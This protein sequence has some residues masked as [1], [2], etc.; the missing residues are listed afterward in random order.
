[1]PSYTKYESVCKPSR[2]ILES[3]GVVN[4]SR[5]N[6]SVII[7]KDGCDLRDDCLGY[8]YSTTYCTHY[9]QNSISDIFNLEAAV[10]VK[11]MNSACYVK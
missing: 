6:G 3:K 11:V 4:Y 1:M 9:I 8:Q 5:G 10:G 7:C 2:R